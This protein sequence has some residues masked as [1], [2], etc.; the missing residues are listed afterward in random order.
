MTKSPAKKPLNPRRQPVQARSNSTVESIL[1]ATTQILVS[2]GY[3]KASTNRI[4]ERAGVSIGS[5]YQ[6]FPNKEAL[7]GTLVQRH[8]DA[9]LQLISG[10]LAATLSME[11]QDALPR[12]VSAMLDAHKLEPELHRVFLEQLPAIISEEKVSAMEQRILVQVK[13]YLQSRKSEIYCEDLDIAAFIV[14]QTVETL[15]HKAVINHPGYLNERLYVEEV[16]RMLLGYLQGQQMVS[17]TG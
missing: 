12:V 13:A 11:M 15:T 8:I 3:E 7:L 9:M 16:S 14:V 4:A 1:E 6:Y 17:G 10:Q 2:Q 5:L